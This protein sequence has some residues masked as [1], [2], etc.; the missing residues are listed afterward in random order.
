VGGDKVILGDNSKNVK[1]EGKDHVV[2]TDTAK[3]NKVSGSKNIQATDNA[4]VNSVNGEKN[5]IV[6]GNNNKLS[7]KHIYHEAKTIDERIV[8]ETYSDVIISNK[9]FIFQS[10]S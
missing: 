5:V 2:A 1:V 8:L 9:R 10:T 6:N 3:I 4:R 7:I